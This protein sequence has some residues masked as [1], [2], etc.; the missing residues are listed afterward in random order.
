MN[1]ERAT[2][3][4]LVVRISSYQFRSQSWKVCRSVPKRQILNPAAY[5]TEAACLISNYACPKR[6]FRDRAFCEVRDAKNNERHVCAGWRDGEPAVSSRRPH[7]PPHLSC[8]FS[9]GVARS[10]FTARIGRAQFYRTR[11]ASKKGDLATPP[12]LNPPFARSR[13]TRCHEIARSIP[14]S[15]KLCPYLTMSS[16]GVCLAIRIEHGGKLERAEDQ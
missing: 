6:F 10:S 13:L 3:S 1:S 5:V 9:K 4:P 11:S 8:F 16:T 14:I 7:R 2:Q 15:V 12:L